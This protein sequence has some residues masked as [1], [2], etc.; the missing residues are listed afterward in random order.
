MLFSAIIEA[1]GPLWKVICMKRCCLLSVSQGS[2]FEYKY[3]LS[4]FLQIPRHS[5]NLRGNA[6]YCA[7]YSLRLTF[8]QR[9]TPVPSRTKFQK[10]SCPKP[11]TVSKVNPHCFHLC[12][13]RSYLCQIFPNAN[14]MFIEEINCL[15][16]VVNAVYTQEE[17][18]GPTELFQIFITKITEIQKETAAQDLFTRYLLNELA[19]DGKTRPKVT[20]RVM[21]EQILLS[22][23]NNL[24]HWLRISSF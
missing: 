22:S 7:S 3:N 13:P 4:S 21:V 11:S 15:M 6:G 2:S 12:N 1:A 17:R 24:M 23:Q 18:V 10:T 16:A 19:M 20:D 9:R 8:I 14:T 5:C